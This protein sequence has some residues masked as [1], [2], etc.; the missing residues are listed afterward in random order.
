[1]HFLMAL[2]FAIVPTTPSQASPDKAT[3]GKPTALAL[4]AAGMKPGTWAELK[5]DNLIDTLRAK[6]ASGA[7]FGYNEDAVWD[8]KTRRFYYVGGDHNDTVRFVT[9]EDKTNA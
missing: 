3:S 9:F 7:I 8:P 4:L 1:M 6:G 2:T 5:T